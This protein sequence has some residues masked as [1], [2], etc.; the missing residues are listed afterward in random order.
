MKSF[1]ALAVL[2]ASVVTAEHA[3]LGIRAHR[4]NLN[5]DVLK[6]MDQLLDRREPLPQVGGID[7][8]GYVFWSPSRTE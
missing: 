7:I 5:P 8:P 6:R 3:P 1:V 4:R 2:L